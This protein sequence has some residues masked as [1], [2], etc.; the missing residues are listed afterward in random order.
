ML[1]KDFIILKVEWEADDEADRVEVEPDKSA[2]ISLDGGAFSADV[3]LSALENGDQK[4]GVTR[5]TTV[6]LAGGTEGSRMRS[7]YKVDNRFTLEP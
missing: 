1:R 7:R 6:D 3:P 5:E 4:I 2:A